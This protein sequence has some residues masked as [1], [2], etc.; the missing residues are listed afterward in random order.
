MPE[1][2]KYMSLSI[3]LYYKGKNGSA[4]AFA[5]EMVDSGIVDR[6]RAED[7]NLRYEYFFPMDDNETVLL[8]DR[9]E[10]QEALN[11]HHKS[12][13]MGEIAKLRDKYGLK[14]NVERYI[15][16]RD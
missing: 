16:E 1:E 13:M 4:R 15:D 6:I 2:R 7:G 5:K 9:W 10:N 3:N 11:R 12:A 14:L 8:I